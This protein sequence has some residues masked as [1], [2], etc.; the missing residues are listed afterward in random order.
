ML[1]N[2][3]LVYIT[4]FLLLYCDN[5]KNYKKMQHPPKTTGEVITELQLSSSAEGEF[6]A[7]F[8][9]Y[10]FLVLEAA[11]TSYPK[12]RFLH[13]LEVSVF[14]GIVFYDPF[15][16]CRLSL[17]AV[18]LQ[19]ALSLFLRSLCSVLGFPSSLLLGSSLSFCSS[20]YPLHIPSFSNDRCWGWCACFQCSLKS[21]RAE[22]S[23]LVSAGAL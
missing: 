23:H 6:L 14:Q 2:R 19:R 3:S 15:F 22:R 18:A 13:K 10:F 20:S 4:T 12:H 1:S 9:I 16:D 21:P 5:S 11:G 7:L 8:L 17:R